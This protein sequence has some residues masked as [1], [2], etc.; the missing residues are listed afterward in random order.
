[1]KDGQ[2]LRQKDEGG[3]SPV[4]ATVETNTSSDPPKL[5]NE[6][7]SRDADVDS[8]STKLLKMRPWENSRLGWIA[9]PQRPTGKF[10]NSIMPDFYRSF[11]PFYPDQKTFRSSF[12]TERKRQWDMLQ[13]IETLIKSIKIRNLQNVSNQASAAKYVKEDYIPRKNDSNYIEELLKQVKEID[14]SIEKID[15]IIKSHNEQLFLKSGKLKSGRMFH[16][17]FNEHMLSELITLRSQTLHLSDQL[18][19]ANKLAKDVFKTQLLNSAV[20]I[21]NKRKY[22]NK[23]KSKKRHALKEDVSKE[24]LEP[25]CKKIFTMLGG[26]LAA[27]E[28]SPEMGTYQITK[29]KQSDIESFPALFKKKE[30]LSALQHLYSSG[31]FREEALSQIEHFLII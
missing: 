14:L 10:Y 18:K 2:D 31:C 4:S 21:K 24:K 15:G 28:Y 5:S 27:E 23:W 1:M 20:A 30:N 22:D 8:Q 16:H 6:E 25:V 3:T 26:H 29:I 17:S 13:N 12:I 19:K 11:W 7:K 9:N